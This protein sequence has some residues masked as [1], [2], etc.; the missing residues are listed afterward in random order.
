MAKLE[1]SILISAP[2]E[3]VFEYASNPVNQPE[4]WP[5]LIEVKNVKE[6]PNGGYSYD[7]IPVTFSKS[8]DASIAAWA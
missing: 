8:L 3:K 4:F 1:S 5:S 2:M 7:F 6:L